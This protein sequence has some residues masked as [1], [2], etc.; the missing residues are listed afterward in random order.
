MAAPFSCA[1][2]SVCSSLSNC[3]RRRLGR[4]AAAV[5]TE[6]LEWHLEPLLHN[7]ACVFIL[8]GVAAGHPYVGTNGLDQQ[9]FAPLY[10]GHTPVPSWAHASLAA[11]LVVRAPSDARLRRSH[12]M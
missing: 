1:F 7:G 11:V 10:S 3:L 8:A 9:A 6:F 12:R 2:R 4:A 5:L